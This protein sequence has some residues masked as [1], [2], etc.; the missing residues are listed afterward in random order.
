VAPATTS[1][2]GTHSAIPGGASGKGKAMSAQPYRIRRD[3]QQY[4]VF[5][6]Y[7]VAEASDRL[8]PGEEQ[9]RWTEIRVYRTEAG[10]YVVEQVM[11]TLWQK[12]E[13]V[14]YKGD[15]CATPQE[16]YRALVGSEADTVLSHLERR[17]LRQLAAQ[18]PRFAAFI[19]A[20]QRAPDA[21]E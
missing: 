2:T 6:G 15:V 13:G 10:S 4:I 7:L 9:E 20:P 18:D 16:V 11:R 12:G 19:A 5:D 8:W 17:I 14:W 21:L 3:G 1:A